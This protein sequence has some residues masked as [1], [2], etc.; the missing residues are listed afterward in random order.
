[1]SNL[2]AYTLF[3]A[4]LSLIAAALSVSTVLSMLLDKSDSLQIRRTLAPL[5]LE[6]A[7]GVA[8]TSLA[9]SLFLSE[10]LNFTPCLLCWVQRGF[11]YPAAILL[12]VQVV[13]S[14]RSKE[15]K[16]PILAYVATVLA[17]FGLPVAIFHRWEQA[18][19]SDLSYCDPV[20]PCSAKWMNE[21]GF[22]TI[23]TMAGIGFFSISVFV[24]LHIKSRSKIS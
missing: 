5:S 9:G 16:K 17:L 11:M 12:G 7:A 10:Y 20:A 6:I 14:N 15:Y 19:G 13:R 24:L 1:M 8:I 2:P 22:I 18:S 3:F 23:P 4:I 21:F